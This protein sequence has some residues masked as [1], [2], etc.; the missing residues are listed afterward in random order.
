MKFSTT[1][2]NTLSTYE[3]NYTRSGHSRMRGINK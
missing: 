1:K 2:R 3:I